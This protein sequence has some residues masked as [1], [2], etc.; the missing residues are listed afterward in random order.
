MRRVPRLPTALAAALT[1]LTLVLAGCSGSEGP[2]L[3]AKKEVR[4]TATTVAGT[5][6]TGAASLPSGYSR[7]AQAKVPMVKVYVT[8]DTKA[9]PSHEFE[10]PWFVNGDSR[11]P[12][13]TVFLVE[14]QRG[15][16]LK[17]LL[18]IRPNGSSGWIKATDV[19]LAP[20]PF[21]IEVDLSDHK[22]EVYNGDKLFLEDTV[23]IGAPETPTPIGRFYI[24][25]LLQP[26]DQNTVYGAYAY[27][28][29][30]HS[31]TL[32]EF[33]GG[34]AEVGIH[35]NNDTSALGKSVSHGCIRMDNAKITQLAKTLM[36]G[37]PVNV[38]A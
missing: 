7:V 36:L 35:G 33:N 24:R 9:A 4:N 30:S 12:V 31:E 38:R 17:V 34:D 18:P 13:Q 21:R 23:A 10:N 14:E 29:S 26:P 2:T 20:N 11:Y 8:P 22:L 28:L 15:E 1:A 16:W 27:G 19:N 6:T 25:V 3:S 32:N 5:A 37:T